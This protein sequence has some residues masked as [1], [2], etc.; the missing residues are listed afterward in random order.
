MVL[1]LIKYLMMLVVG[2]PSVFWVGSKK[3]CYEWASFLQGRRRK[4][5]G[6][7]ESR[8]VLQE[9]P[10]FTQSLLRE[11]NTPVIRKSRGTSTQGT[12]THASSTNLAVIDDLEKPQRSHPGPSSTRSRGSSVHSKT[13]Y[14]GSLRR[15]RE[16]RSDTVAPRATDEQSLHC[17]VPQPEE[18]AS[19][20]VEQTNSKQNS[21]RDPAEAPA[22]V[23]THGT[24][25][26][27]SRTPENNGTSA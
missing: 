2:I 15:T 5:S 1:F 23:I 10:D 20:Q 21:Q 12:S 26:L 25:A 11:P 8:Q 9:Q 3:T 16:D 18:P 6:V 17:G 14:H 13:S 19:A 4:D 24:T 7:N 22:T 27:D